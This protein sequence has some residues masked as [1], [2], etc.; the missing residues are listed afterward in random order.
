MNLLKS[1][2]K[3]HFVCY[4]V[5]RMIWEGDKMIVPITGNVKFSITMDPT[6]W[7][8]DDRKI[9]LEEAFTLQ[10]QSVEED[11]ITKAAK[12]WDRELYH[13]KVK[14][15]VNKTLTKFEREKVLDHSYVMPL[16]DFLGHAEIK[17]NAKSA[18]LVTAKKEIEIS[19]QQLQECYLL[20]AKN[21]K[22]L[23]A[24]GPVHILFKDGSNKDNPIKNV[25]KISIN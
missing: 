24:D 22:P 21:G 6:V 17:S 16:A 20:F 18:T 13:Q 4:S 12:R 7:I 19:L 15:P 8:F 3:N 9:I 23:I 5:K 10:E 2:E 14:P 11:E 1:N 25:Q